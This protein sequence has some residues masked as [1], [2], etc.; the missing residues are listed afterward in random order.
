MKSDRK[1][2][3]K[4]LVVVMMLACLPLLGRAYASVETFVAEPER[5]VTLTV[6]SNGCVSIYGNIS[7]MQGYVDFYITDPSGNTLCLFN[8]TAFTDFNIASPENGTY[9]FH[10]ANPW[11][12]NNVTATLFYGKS[13]RVVIQEEMRM[14]Q[15]IST[16]T[17]TT[18][19][20]ATPALAWIGPL[21]EFQISVLSGVLV[22][23]ISA[24]L[25]DVFREKR[26]KWKDGE[27]KTPVVIKHS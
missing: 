25:I 4:T 5:E 8:M 12:P 14:W 9:T 23:I 16:S 10:I 6:D 2:F 11:S 3:R 27:S 19:T 18:S 21:T 22:T 26:Q 1:M 20:T 17:F 13:F 7:I 24:L 15:E